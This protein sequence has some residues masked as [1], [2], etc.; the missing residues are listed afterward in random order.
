MRLKLPHKQYEDAVTRKPP[1]KVIT[2][3]SS[4][5]SVMIVFEGAHAVLNVVCV[6]LL[7]FAVVWHCLRVSGVR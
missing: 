4:D 6:G 5:E 1:D 2:F 7:R 3:D